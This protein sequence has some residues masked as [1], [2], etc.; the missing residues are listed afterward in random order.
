MRII[1][2]AALGAA[3]LLS[4]AIGRELVAEEACTSFAVVE[5]SAGRHGIAIVHDLRGADAAA[6]LAAYNAVPP[7]TSLAGDQVVLLDGQGAPTML[8]M[9][10]ADGCLTVW[11]EEGHALVEL[12]TADVLP[13]A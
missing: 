2:T 4:G 8:V 9:V 10:F 12:I 3:F 5:E 7:V 13:G 11:W 6:W 1:G